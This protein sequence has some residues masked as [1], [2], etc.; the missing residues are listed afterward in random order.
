MHLPPL[1]PSRP[2]ARSPASMSRRTRARWQIVLHVPESD[3]AASNARIRSRRERTRRDEAGRVL[4]NKANS[5]GSRGAC[6]GSVRRA[7]AGVAGANHV[8]VRIL[9]PRGRAREAG[10][11]ASATPEILAR[12]EE[13][14]GIPYP[15]DKL[16]HVA[17]LDMP[18]GAVENPGLITYRDSILLARPERDTLERQRAHARHHGPR[19]RAPVVREPGDAGVVERGVAERGVCHVARRED[20]RPRTA[21]L[22]ARS[23]RRAKPRADDA[24]RRGPPTPV[25]YGSR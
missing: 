14:T 10:P 16:D 22:R 5:F 9:A 3:V 25:R 18:Y 24:G 7:D 6:G 2:A 15:W 11:A 19:T 4:R 1:P 8:P 17:V 20:Q 13:Y 23:R 12:L 21:G